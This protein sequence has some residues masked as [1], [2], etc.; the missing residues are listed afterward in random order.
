LHLYEHIEG[1]NT[2]QILTANLKV[3]WLIPF[4]FTKWQGD[5]KLHDNNYILIINYSYLLGVFKCLHLF[6]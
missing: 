5:V 6:F 2:S 3:N 1:G 4:G